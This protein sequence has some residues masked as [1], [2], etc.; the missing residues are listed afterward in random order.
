[1][2]TAANRSEAARKAAATR[3][4]IKLERA[5][6]EAYHAEIKAI[7]KSGKCPQCGGP[8]RRN[9]SMAGWWQCGQFGNP[10]YRLNPAEPDCT[11]QGF[12]E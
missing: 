1:M 7:V 8:L 6:R 3:K 4:Q 5:R 2:Q 12:T 11:W 10:E 9:N